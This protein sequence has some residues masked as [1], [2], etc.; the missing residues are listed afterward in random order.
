MEIAE[1]SPE[2]FKKFIDDPKLESKAVI[3]RALDA[4]VIAY[5]PVENKFTWTANGATIAM[6]ER[7]EDGAYIEQ[8][9]DWFM[10]HKN[11]L[12]TYKKIKGQLTTKQPA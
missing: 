9:A 7:T 6:L 3:R 4:N 5:I 11:G 8:L 2:F 12:D 10:S 1:K